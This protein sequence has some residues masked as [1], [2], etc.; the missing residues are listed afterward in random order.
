MI[1]LR[2]GSHCLR[3][4]FAVWCFMAGQTT[5]DVAMLLG[6]SVE[7]VARHYSQW[8]HGRQERLTERMKTALTA[9]HGAA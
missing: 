8:I 5:E 9:R 4:S 3:H 1:P 6:D 2:F 7:V